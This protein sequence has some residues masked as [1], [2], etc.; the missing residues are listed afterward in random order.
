MHEKEFGTSWVAQNRAVIKNF[1]DDFLENE[2]VK[3]IKLPGDV[4]VLGP[5]IFGSFEILNSAGEAVLTSDNVLNA[6][7]IL[8]AN[9]HK[10]ESIKIPVDDEAVKIVVKKYEKYLDELLAKIKKDFDGLFPK[11]PKLMEIINYIFVSLNLKR[12]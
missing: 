6:K 10:P 7:Y 12:Y 3:E 2:E 5:E 4:L 1:P 9:R 11:S 8:Y